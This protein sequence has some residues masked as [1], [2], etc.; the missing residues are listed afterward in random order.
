MLETVKNLTSPEYLISRLEGACHSVTRE[1]NGF[2]I[3][4]LR[5]A[6][7][8]SPLLFA[9]HLDLPHFICMGKA[10]DKFS[11]HY[12]GNL[13]GGE[14]DECPAVSETGVKCTVTTA[15][16]KTTATAIE[17]IPA[18]EL[19]FT[20]SPAAEEDERIIL[21]GVSALAPVSALVLAAESLAETQLPRDVYFAFIPDGQYGHGLYGATALRIGAAEAV[22]IGAI[23]EKFAE[24]VS[25]RLCERGF[26][27]DKSIS[28]RLIA[29]GAIPV[30]L[31]DGRCAAATVQLRGVPASQ[32]DVPVRDGGTASESV[33]AAHIRALAD[34][35]TDF[36]K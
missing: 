20:D 11:L 1:K 4:R 2:I 15:D 6:D 10:D 3:A 9:T 12:V 33:D 8:A 34:I 14:W 7:C 28:D 22:C 16:G 35:I 27:S 32:L 36:I 17:D 19:V 25:V 30:T 24:G 5:G 13:G 29:A 26:A 31:R 23:D 18:G 21:H